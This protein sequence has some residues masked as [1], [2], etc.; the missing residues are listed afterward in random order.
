MH[1]RAGPYCNTYS[2]VCSRNDDERNDVDSNC[3]PHHIQLLCPRRREDRPA[4]VPACPDVDLAVAPD[5]QLRR[6]QHAG[7][8]PRA[9]DQGPC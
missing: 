1:P 5:T 2:T 4:L 7:S 8:G 6:G 9:A 3:R